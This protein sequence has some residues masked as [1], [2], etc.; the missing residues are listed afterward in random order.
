MSTDLRRMSHDEISAL[1]EAAYLWP[2]C[3][4]RPVIS[5]QEPPAPEEVPTVQLDLFG[6]EQ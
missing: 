6:Q 4:P 1:N 2:R 3:K 5:A